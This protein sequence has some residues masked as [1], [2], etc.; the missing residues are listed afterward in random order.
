[1]KD[2][3]ST[4]GLVLSV[5]LVKTAF[6]F[7]GG[8]VFIKWYFTLLLMILY[9]RQHQTFVTPL[10]FYLNVYAAAIMAGR[11]FDESRT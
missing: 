9:N 6:F 8:H 11:I 2:E 1:M 3:V 5:T 7:G 4:I 10:Y